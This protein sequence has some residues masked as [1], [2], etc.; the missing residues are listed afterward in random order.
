[1]TIYLD[2]S[3]SIQDAGSTADELLQDL[4]DGKIPD[5][6]DDHAWDV[7][8]CCLE[9][10]SAVRRFREEAASRNGYLNKNAE[11]RMSV[12]EFV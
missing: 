6:S 12:S 2:L 8:N 9:L 4:Y 1:M 7:Q 11:H 3:G 5:Y 10:M